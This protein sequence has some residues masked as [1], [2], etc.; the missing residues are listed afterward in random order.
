LAPAEC[1]LLGE[2]VGLALQAAL[3]LKLEVFEAVSMEMQKLV[4]EFPTGCVYGDDRAFFPIIKEGL[5]KRLHIASG[6]LVRDG[7]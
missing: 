5:H 7:K 2:Q 1:S 4:K 6:G 3:S